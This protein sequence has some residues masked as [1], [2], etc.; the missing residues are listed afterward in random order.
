MPLA[1]V[2]NHKVS[3]AGFIMTAMKKMYGWAFIRGM[4]NTI[5]HAV[6]A[7]S[8]KVCWGSLQTKSVVV[9]CWC[10]LLVLF[11]EVVCWCSLLGQFVGVVCWGSLLAMSARVVVAGRLV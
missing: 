6:G 7:K 9:V 4:H 1:D 5:S 11:V 3:N 8:V 10:S 2:F